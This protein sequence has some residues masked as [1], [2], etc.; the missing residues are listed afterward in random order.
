[1]PIPFTKITL[2]TTI[3]G[4]GG[5]A[6][7]PQEGPEFAFAYTG[8]PTASWVSGIADLNGDGIAEIITGV[9]GSNDKAAGA[10]RIYLTFGKA[11]GGAAATLGDTLTQFIIDGAKGNDHAGVAIA[12]IAD[13]NGGGS[14]DLLIGSPFA[15]KTPLVDAGAAYVVWS[16]S[17]I[18]SVDLQDLGANGSGQGYIIRGEASGDHAGEALASIADQNGDAKADIL[19]GAAGNDAGGV[20]AGA[21]YV[22][23]G[24]A[25]DTAVNLTD[26]TAGIGGYRIIGQAAGD[27]A[28]AAL[29]AIGD[30]NGDGRAE[31][32][33]GAAGNDAGGLNA[34]AAYVVFGKATGTQ[35]DLDNVAAG[36]GGFRITGAAAG[37]QAGGAISAIGDVNGD[38]RTDLLVGAAGGGKAYVVY[39]KADTNEVLL[40]S[41][42]SGIGGF[43]ILPESAGDFVGLSVTG[44]ADLNRDGVADL[45]IGT[46]GNTEGGVNAG[47]VYV[48]W[49]G[50][51]GP[52]DL[53]AIALG[54]GG[55]KIVGRAN[56]FTGSAVS[57]TGDMNG[58][59]TADLVIGAPGGA[60]AAVSILYAPASWQPDANVY[61]TN[62]ADTIGV[63]AGGLHVVG[64]GADSIFALDGN[65]SIFA[66]GGADVVD[67]GAGNDTADGGDGDDTLLGGLGADSLIGGLGDDSLDGGIGIDRMA[68]GAG[69][70]TYVVDAVGDVVTELPGG[71]ADTVRAAVSYTLSADLEN[72]VLT[73]GGLTGIGNATANTLTGSEGNDTLA[74]GGDND[75]L[76]GNGGADSLDGG[77]GVDSLVGGSGND[78]YVL[79]VAG[80]VVIELAGG[81]FDTVVAAFDYTLG[82][83]LEALVLTGTAKIGTGNAVANSLIGGTG[84]DSLSGLAGNDSLQGG[85]GN[86]LLDGGTEADAMT[87]GT[88]DDRY[89]VDS[90]GD[91]VFEATLGG[92]DTVEASVDYTLTAEVETLILS[93]L[94]RRGTGNLDANAI[95][96]TTGDDTLSGGG[97]NDSLT[98]GLGADR[99]DGGTGDDTLVGGGGNDTYLIDAVADVV[100]E[101]AG[102]G[103]DTVLAG[104]D[105]TLGAQVEALVLTGT[106]HVG[107]GNTQANTITGGDGAD[108]LSGLSGVDTLLGAGGNDRLDG[109]TGADSMDGGAGNDTYVVDNAGDIASESLGGGID[110]VLASVN[111]TLGDNVE[112]L[113][114]TGN[115]HVGTG[116][117]LD[118][119]ITGGVGIDSLN[120]GGGNDTLDGGAG[121][122]VLTGGD[123]DDT[124]LIG[125]PGDVVVEA[126]GG[127]FDTVVVNTDWTLADNIE[128][129]QLVG[130]GHALT[131]N[132]AN[133][134]ISGN[135]GNDTLDGGDGD[136]TELGG[137]GADV[138]IS[139]SGRD[140]LSG[141]TGDDRFEVHGGSV[142]FEDFL[143]HDTI[144]ASN[145]LGDSYVDLSGET[146]SEIENEVCDIG[147]GG[148]AAGPLDLQFL[149][150]LTGSFADDIANVRVLIPQIV[151]ALQAVQIDSTFG[152]STFRDKAV[153]PF[154]NTGDWVYQLGT[155][156]A[157]DTAALTTAYNA[158]VAANGNDGPEAQIEAL[159]HLALTTGEVGYR[160]NS[161]RFVVL[162]T[163]APFHQA[164]DGATGGIFT[165]NNGD[166]V[167]DGTPPGTG[168]DY[169]AIAQLKIA[170]ELANI[171]PIFA[172]AGGFDATYRDLVTQLG[173][174]TEVTITASS[175]DVVAAITAGLT[176]ATTTVIEDCW[177]GA[178]ND[179]LK[180][181][182]ADNGLVGGAGNDS[183]DG[184]LGA[185]QLTG[186]L[187]DD[188]YVIDAA[189]DVV[190]ENLGEG[191]DAV[192]SAIDYT[193][194]ANFE[195]LVVT[196]TATSGTGNTLANTLT[197]NDLGD[198]LAGL[199]G[200]DT[201]LGGAGNDS[202]DGGTGADRLVGG[203]GD[204][205]YVVDLGGDVVVETLGGGIDTV[206]ASRTWTLG[207]EL[208]VL[209][210]VGLAANGTG[211]TLANSLFGN[212]LVNVL[213][214]GGDND[215]LD[216]GLANDVLK[217]GTGDDTLIGG[218]GVD[219]LTGGTGAD[220]F[221]FAQVSD[222]GDKILDFSVVDDTLEFSA[223]GFGGGLFADED[224]VA[225]H[226]LVLGARADS[227]FG[228]FVYDGASGRLSWDA[229][230]TGI[231]AKV[232]VA[233]LTGL[234]TLT[235]ADLHIIA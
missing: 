111:T 107:T 88:G 64:D 211:N 112:A 152:V 138:L 156:L 204:D 235:E 134:V 216:G 196:G 145:A 171:I 166:A 157:N 65:D 5:Y 42:A 95:I 179:T 220:L 128:G 56:S 32:L 70:D 147:Q 98:G 18:G 139:K 124:Y 82:A 45:V 190:T 80:D 113:V 212:D 200:N 214:G 228:Q 120:G 34:G 180:G 52:I 158:M 103:S 210:L 66:A 186:G 44:G 194:G 91:F 53:S 189:G 213:N 4:A 218:T 20:D 1:M 195:A 6:L 230:G 199:E 100:T 92:S 192:Q 102:G 206:V 21:A 161:A 16:P 207:A 43:V 59:G 63:G 101:G 94:A 159:M 131:G 14:P 73:L 172:V 130:G 233:A 8:L 126:I 38:A 9:P 48:V 221:R 71:G 57:I 17:G 68:G 108:T 105:Y 55:A 174:G 33:V 162:F 140:T 217:G 146:G 225:D 127:G 197:A 215:L 175:S 165:P 99:L 114:L 54:A 144:D 74:G 173:R 150:D 129:V 133:N 224:L 75:T 231:G 182:D 203:A 58:D 87:G 81:G 110:T 205:T 181:N 106:A 121:A 115:A 83:E 47:A 177:G 188:T 49:G 125:D 28:G 142:R 60:N 154:G 15:E 31:I 37:D 77:A 148:N 232:L 136:D 25:T 187:G 226:R 109:G 13:L 96:G 7:L 227:A 122:D 118:N 160:T 41:V 141:G 178:G 27:G 223:A 97:G 72:M 149:Q 119:S 169:P 46:P 132:A 67:A 79:D 191:A 11:T 29:G 85:G 76:I 89:I 116:N 104:V 84:N 234:P 219:K 167:L 153:S 3:G 184:G 30:L 93:G 143:G 24:K 12:T 198:T 202:L 19:V 90:F 2:A 39:G 151:A 10:G 176:A 137:D 208:E 229:D 163:D 164:G 168:E 26:V 36:A 23:F 185:D 222:G 193:L 183:L 201:L 35:I 51:R 209:R 61:G 155:G 62:A 78:A 40:S 69:N 22:V 170:L 117:A 86:D 123:G 135:T 50:G